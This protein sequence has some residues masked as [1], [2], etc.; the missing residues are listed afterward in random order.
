MDEVRAKHDCKDA[1]VRAT[2]ET[3][4]R[5]PESR[6]PRPKEVPPQSIPTGD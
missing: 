6:R 2:Q 3:K 5:K 1:G 4:P